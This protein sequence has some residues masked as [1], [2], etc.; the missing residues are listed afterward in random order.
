MIRFESGL[1]CNA[2]MRAWDGKSCQG[3]FTNVLWGEVDM[4]G[5]ARIRLGAPRFGDDIIGRASPIMH[6]GWSE[7]ERARREVEEA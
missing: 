1:D 4:V 3:R 6:V 5:P 7:W 2:L